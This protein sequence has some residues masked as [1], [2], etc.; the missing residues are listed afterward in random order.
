[1]SR[2]DCQERRSRLLSLVLFTVDTSSLFCLGLGLSGGCRPVPE[3]LR[4]RG[5]QG[6]WWWKLIGEHALNNLCL[7]SKPGQIA[8]PGAFSLP[9]LREVNE[10]PSCLVKRESF[11]AS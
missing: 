8:L 3:G 11:S 5:G 10:I 4:N 6:S 2:V 9:I 7:S 1:M